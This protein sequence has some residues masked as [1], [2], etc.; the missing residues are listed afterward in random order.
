MRKTNPD[1][2]QMSSQTSNGKL[3]AKRADY[4]HKKRYPDTGHSD[5]EKRKQL[6]N[7]ASSSGFTDSESEVLGEESKTLGAARAPLSGGRPDSP[8][9]SA[10]RVGRDPAPGESGRPPLRGARAAPNPR[11]GAYKGGP[12]GKMSPV[13]VRSFAR[14]SAVGQRRPKLPGPAH[15]RAPTARQLPDGLAGSERR[16][17]PSRD[18]QL[19]YKVNRLHNYWEKEIHSSATVNR[20]ISQQQWLVSIDHHPAASL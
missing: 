1:A 18:R 20:N 10:A 5:P 11:A 8:V 16:R 14:G 2:K 6:L 19:D 17:S 12:A 4:F 9:P 15:E 13:C 3:S 7:Q